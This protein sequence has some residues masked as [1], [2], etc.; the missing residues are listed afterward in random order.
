MLVIP[1]PGTAGLTIPN[2]PKIVVK[3]YEAKLAVLPGLSFVIDP[4]LFDSETFVATDRI[5][6]VGV[7]RSAA[8]TI[9]KTSILL[10]GRP[11]F[12][13]PSATTLV[14]A[15]A[16]TQ[17]AT[18]T[19]IIVTAPTTLTGEGYTYNGPASL[20]RNNNSVQATAH[21]LYVTAPGV[22]TAVNTPM[23]LAY[24]ADFASLELFCYAWKSGAAPGEAIGVRASSPDDAAL[25]GSQFLIGRTNLS[26]PGHYGL[27][28]GFSEALHLPGNRGRFDDA[29]GMLAEYYGIT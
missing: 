1:V 25:L 28:I 9:D 29:V 18:Q 11:A 13:L 10:G 19:V 6:G 12:V 8:T 27:A 15:A 14:T 26:V 4:D 17:R 16:G 5:A 22:V 24:S 7:T 3:D 20:R 21:P 2:A 23:I